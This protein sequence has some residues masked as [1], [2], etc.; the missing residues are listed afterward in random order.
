MDNDTIGMVLAYFH[1]LG[2]A[3][4]KA[5]MKKIVE[6][7]SEEEKVELAKMILEKK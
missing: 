4:K 6:R 7:L 5:I 3:D 1:S 2:K